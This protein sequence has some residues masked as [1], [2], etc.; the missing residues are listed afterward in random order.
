[1]SQPA[2]AARDVFGFV[3]RIPVG[4][5]L[6]FAALG[7][8]GGAEAQTRPREHAIQGVDVQK[9][10][11][12][13]V[14]IISYTVAPDVTTSSLSITDA[15]TSNPDLSMTQFGGGFVVSDT[16][17]LYL[18]GNAA[19]S[20]YD[21]RFV[22]SDG[23]AWADAEVHQARGHGVHR[24]A[25]LRVAGRPVAIFER[26]LGAPARGE[27]VEHLGQRGYGQRR[28]PAYAGW[29]APLPGPLLSHRRPCVDVGPVSMI[30]ER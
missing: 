10:A 17:R 19:W 3:R 18:E 14:G 13:I 28:V 22:V 24:G 6:A 9:L 5:P 26:R 8:W 16:T 11:N 12:G 4:L 7:A 1:M 20:R 23:H 25:Q 2:C 27:G 30:P 15:G 21:P 29:V